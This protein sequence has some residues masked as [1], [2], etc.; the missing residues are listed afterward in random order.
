MAQ[1]MQKYVGFIEMNDGT[2]FG[3]IRVGLATKIQAEKTSKANNWAPDRDGAT[4]NS[5]MAY[6]AAKTAGL[7]D[8]TWDEFKANVLDATTATLEVD[9]DT[10]DAEDPTHPAATAD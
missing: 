4:I 5:F 8:I 10:T 3:P 9:Q 7:I 6:H 1:Q 2:E